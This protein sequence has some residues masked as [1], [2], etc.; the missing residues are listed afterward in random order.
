M[1]VVLKINGKKA[2]EGAPLLLRHALVNEGSL[3]AHD[4]SNGG[5]FVSNDIRNGS[6]LV[7]LSRE[8]SL[9]HGVDN[10]AFLVTAPGKED[11][12]EYTAGKG[13]RIGSFTQSGGLENPQGFDM[14]LDLPNYLADNQPNFLAIFWVRNV[15]SNNGSFF[16]CT[17]EGNYFFSFRKTSTF[18]CW[19]AGTSSGGVAATNGKLFQFGVEFRGAGLPL[20]RYIDGVINGES[21]GAATGFDSG[22]ILPAL[23]GSRSIANTDVVYYGDFMYD[24]GKTSKTAEELVKENWD[25]VQGTGVYAGK[26]TKRPFVDVP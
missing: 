16:S 25:Y 26:P 6:E 10:R 19:L 18:H 2:P 23:I 4:F 9:G 7:D 12:V 3:M 21:D 20:R 8:I 15:G 13:I 1:G 14:G 5:S 24:L 17:G 11:S 22:E